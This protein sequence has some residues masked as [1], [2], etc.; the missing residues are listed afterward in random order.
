MSP[1]IV[2]LSIPC[3]DRSE[4]ITV[5]LQ[6]E[7]PVYKGYECY[8]YDVGIKSHYGTYFEASGH[9]FREGKDTH[10]IALEKLILPGVCLRIE[11]SK[12]C[13][14]AEALQKAAEEVKIEPGS[15]LLVSIKSSSVDDRSYFSLD[16]AEW[17]A[18]KRVAL[19]GSDTRYY[20]RGFENPTGFFVDLFRAEIPIIANITN[21]W[22]LPQ[23]GFTLYTF[24]LNIIGVCVV[25]SRVVAVID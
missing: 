1:R 21:L 24:P 13:I 18:E 8:A 9:L 11:D 14:D 2:D 15:A 16:A 19:M 17:M 25:P 12:R 22:E 23:T 20:D 10:E 3:N 7:L 6:K 5:S 4:G